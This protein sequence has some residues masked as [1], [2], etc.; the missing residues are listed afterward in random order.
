MSV[1]NSALMAYMDLGIIPEGAMDNDS[2]GTAPIGTGPYQVESYT[3]NSETVL[4]AY[5]DY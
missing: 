1:A 3:L 5:E 4:K 2:F